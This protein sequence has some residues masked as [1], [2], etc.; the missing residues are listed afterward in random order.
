MNYGTR[1][2]PKLSEIEE[3]MNKRFGNRNTKT[4]KWMGI[5]FSEE[6]YQDDMENIGQES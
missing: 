1:K 2:P 3:I 6:E 5:K 4:N